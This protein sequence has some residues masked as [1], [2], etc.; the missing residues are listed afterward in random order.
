MP[1]GLPAYLLACL[2]ACVGLASAYL[3]TCV[4]SSA[5]P[6][7]FC[8]THSLISGLRSLTLLQIPV[9]SRTTTLGCGLGL[10]VSVVLYFWM[11]VCL[12]AALFPRGSFVR[13]RSF[14]VRSS[15]CWVG[16]AVGLLVGRSVGPS[17]SE[18]A[19]LTQV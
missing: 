2:L 16:G 11:C 5:L 12:D 14:F 13:V 7:L 6:D 3:S 8:L 15:V 19:G 17:V 9:A 4:P 10:L 1:T 18:S